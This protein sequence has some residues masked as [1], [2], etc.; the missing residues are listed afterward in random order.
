MGNTGMERRHDTAKTTC[1][2]R[3]RHHTK[4]CAEISPKTTPG[5]REKIR[6]NLQGV[7]GEPNKLEKWTQQE[8]KKGKM[9][10][11]KVQ[12][13]YNRGCRNVTHQNQTRRQA[14]NHNQ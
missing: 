4:T 11:K 10:Q 6:Y 3:T 8:K 12:Q 7:R 5:G 1:N 14:K 13:K 9:V 2:L